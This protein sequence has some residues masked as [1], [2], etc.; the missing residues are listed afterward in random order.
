VIG[1]NPMKRNRTQTFEA[2]A[3]RQIFGLHDGHRCAKFVLRHVGGSKLGNE[4]TSIDNQATDEFVETLMDEMQSAAENDAAAMPVGVQTYVVQAYYEGEEKP[5]ARWTLRAQSEDDSDD[6][7]NASEPPTPT[8]LV[9]QTQRHLEVVM[10][11]NSLGLTTVLQHMT[12]TINRLSAQNEALLADKLHQIEVV[13][14]LAK[15]THE[16]ELDMRREERRALATQAGI[17]KL[18][19]LLP[20]MIKKLTGKQLLPS[21]NP[22]V[23][24]LKSFFGSVTT[25]QLEG[26][27]KLLSPD[28]VGII[29]SLARDYLPETPSDNGNKEAPQQ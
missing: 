7:P 11:A 19:M 14:T 21:E 2:W 3:R 23:V 25:D 17:E 20:H 5:A 10:R 22:T 29:L 6:A 16:R 28:Q 15:A 26:L 13:E 8:G 27:Q 18:S 9:A 24:A 1:W 4:V 12:N